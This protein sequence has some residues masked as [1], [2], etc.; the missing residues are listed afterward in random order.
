[1]MFYLSLIKT[2]KQKPIVD[3]QKIKE[4][5]QVYHHIKSSSNKKKKTDQENKK[6][7]KKL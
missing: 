4:S 5:K 6:G 3:A 2:I 1:M 7:I